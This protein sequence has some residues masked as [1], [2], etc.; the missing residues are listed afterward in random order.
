MPRPER[1]RKGCSLSNAQSVGLVYLERDHKRFREIKELFKT[2]KEKFGVRRVGMMS[3]VDEDPK[4]TPT[5]LVKKLDSGY[6]CKGDLNWHGW[7]V[8]EFEAFV[9]TPFDILI[10]LNRACA[11]T[12]IHRQIQPGWDESWHGAHRLNDDLDFR[13]VRE[14]STRP[15]EMDEVDV[16]LHDPMEEW[17]EHTRRTLDFLQNIDLQ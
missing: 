1:E 11:A 12:E 9:D 2:L 4:D 14:H 17:Q 8:K 3:F 16:I 10:D 13:V 15:E 7:P 6:F 5:W